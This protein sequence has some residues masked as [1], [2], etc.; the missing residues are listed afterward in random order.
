ME[1]FEYGKMEMDY[2]KKQDKKLS[3][4]IDRFGL[5]KREVQRNCF[6]ALIESII[7]QQI[8]SKAAETVWSRFE[9][10][11][12]GS[13]TAE[14]IAQLNVDKIKGCGIS[15]RKADY[16]MG[17]ANAVLHGE[18]NFDTLGQYSDK[19][20]IA[21]LTALRGVGVWTAEMLLLFSLCRTDVVSYGDLAIR[22]GMQT[23][24]GLNEL[25][26]SVFEEYRKRYSPYGSVASFYLWEISRE[27]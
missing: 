7:S 24:Y 10:L 27:I 26:K 9:S 18:I 2:L 20:I 23:L 11:L 12:S 1:Y 5:I 8:S 3:K 21:K 15:Y 19:E 14:G 16:I 25:P 4:A 22:R 17:I 6:V 13:V